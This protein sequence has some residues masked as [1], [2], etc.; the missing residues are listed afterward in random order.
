MN[1]SLLLQIDSDSEFRFLA[2]S[3]DQEAQARVPVSCHRSWSLALGAHDGKPHP[4]FPK[5]LGGSSSLS[6]KPFHDLPSPTGNRGAA[7]YPTRRLISTQGPAARV[8][9]LLAWTSGN[10]G[11]GTVA[12][13]HSGLDLEPASSFIRPTYSRLHTL[14]A[15]LLMCWKFS[16]L[17]AGP[18]MI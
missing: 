14:P 9:P 10:I 17:E 2:R 12:H 18:T 16:C 6:T 11:V 1:V 13:S 4:S 3:W 8:R 15:S 5:T 7:R